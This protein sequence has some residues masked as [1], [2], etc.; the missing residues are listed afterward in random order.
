[1]LEND[2]KIEKKSHL[3]GNRCLCEL[4]SIGNSDQQL[5]QVLGF[6]VQRVFQP[7]RALELL[8]QEFSVV[9]GDQRVFQLPDGV[10]VG[11]LDCRH[12]LS[13]AQI[14]RH[15]VAGRQIAECRWAVIFVHYGYFNLQARKVRKLIT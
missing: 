7:Q 2:R 6:S 13:G 9:A 1:M 8:Q 15:H 4:H 14:F 10:G 11:C 3:N 12:Q 5:V